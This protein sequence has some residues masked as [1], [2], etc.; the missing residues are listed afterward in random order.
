MSP[1]TGERDH[2]IQS[3]ILDSEGGSAVDTSASTIPKG[4]ALDLTRVLLVLHTASVA[5]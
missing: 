5:G 1:A 4:R 2:V 3:G